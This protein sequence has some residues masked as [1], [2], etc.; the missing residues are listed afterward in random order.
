MI[1]LTLPL[2]PSVNGLYAN[3]PGRGRVRSDRYRKWATSAGW[4]LKA[5][6]PGKV[7]GDY[8]LWVW[9]ERPDKRKRDLGNLE[10]PLSDLL[11]EHGVVGDDSQCTSLHMYWSGSGRHCRVQVKPA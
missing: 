5:Q 7:D 2:P 9:C 1:E 4:D 6:K 8:V 3:V 10:K 11:V